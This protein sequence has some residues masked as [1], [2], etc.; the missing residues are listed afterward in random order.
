MLVV[1]GAV[2]HRQAARAVL[3]AV[4]RAVRVQRVRLAQLTPEAAAVVEVAVNK[5]AQADQV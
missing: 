2:R 3:A 4:V 1:E 5:V